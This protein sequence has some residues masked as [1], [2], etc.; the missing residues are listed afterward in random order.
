MPQTG[1]HRRETARE[2]ETSESSSSPTTPLLKTLRLAWCW[3]ADKCDQEAQDREQTLIVKD[4]VRQKLFD[5]TKLICPEDLKYRD[6]SRSLCQQIMG[7]AN[8]ANEH[9]QECW[10]VAKQIVFKEIST[11]RG[12]KTN[13]IKKEF[14][15]KMC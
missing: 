3:K 13:M 9:K 8:I 6:S 1:Y 15:C 2:E 14:L 5:Y 7:W 4:I 12:T 10:S 11:L